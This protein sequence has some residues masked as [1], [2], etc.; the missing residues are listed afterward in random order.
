[1]AKS[2]NEIKIF[3]LSSFLND[4]GSDMIYPIWPHF[5]RNILGANMAILGLLD[6]IGETLVSISQAVSGYYSDKIK[7]R[8]IFIWFGYLMGS[9]SRIGYSISS[10]WQT[11]LPFR[12]LDRAGKIRSAPRDAIIA[13]ISTNDNRGKNFGLLRTADNLGAVAGIVICLVLINF[14]NIKTILLLAAIPSLLSVILIIFFIKETKNSETKIFKGLQL[15]FFN[16]NFRLFLITSGIFSIG[17][18]SYSFLLLF[19]Q[20][21][22]TKI[23]ILPIFYLIFTIAAALSSY[24]FGYLADKIGRKSIILIGYL[25]WIIVCIGFIFNKNY[26]VFIFLFLLYGF[27]KGALETVQ[28]AFVSELGPDDYKASSL[29]GFQMIIGL[30]AFP[31]SLIAG[32]LWDQFGKEFIM[33]FSIIMSIISSIILIFIKEKKAYD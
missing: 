30:C 3:A 6:G 10:N 21:L 27:H 31:A 22:G 1:M 26:I 13:D 23:Y 20:E 15:K 28:K 17:S 12:I 16:K 24:P 4:L 11:V 7:K 9:L 25:I 19:T 33:F 18:F 29:G 14:L 8:K 32:I 2:R 5:I